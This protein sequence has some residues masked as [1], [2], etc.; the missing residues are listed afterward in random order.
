VD[1]KSNMAALASDWLTNFRLLKNGCKLP[2]AESCTIL[3]LRVIGMI[4]LHLVYWF[5]RRILFFK[6]KSHFGGGPF[7]TL[8]ASF[9]QT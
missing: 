6:N 3:Y 7:V 8:E 5:I 4:Y 1:P 9:E 2:R